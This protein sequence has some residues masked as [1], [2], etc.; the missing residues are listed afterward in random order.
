MF[1]AAGRQTLLATRR[2]RSPRRSGA[3]R[4]LVD[5]VGYLLA[6]ATICTVYGRQGDLRGRRDLLLV[7]LA[8]SPPLARLRL[9][10][11][12]CAARRARVLQGL[13]AAG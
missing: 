2:R 10:R 9:S 12:R 11:N 4:Q 8:C 6:S 1:M 3:A 7:A 5:V 13:G